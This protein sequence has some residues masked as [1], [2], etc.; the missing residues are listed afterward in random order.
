MGNSAELQV[1]IIMPAYNAERFIAAT[2]ESVLRQTCPHWELIIVDDGSEDSTANIAL[3]YADLDRR[4]RLVRQSHQ[5]LAEARNAGISLALGQ[6]IAFLDSDDLWAPEK[7]QRQIETINSTGA[8]LVYTDGY[9]FSNDD[10]GDRSRTCSIPIGQYSGDE[11]FALL[12]TR[13]RFAVSSVMLWRWCLDRAG[14]FDATPDHF[15]AEDYDLWL[16]LAG[17]GARFYGMPDRLIAYRV[18]DQSLSRYVRLM[19][20]S[21]GMVMR[22]HGLLN[23]PEGRRA[24]RRYA[25]VALLDEYYICNRNGNHDLAW[26]FMRQAWASSPATLCQP[27]RAAAVI[28]NGIM[29]RIFIT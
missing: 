20:N 26:S 6:L 9:V 5:R 19:I 15:G 16:T 11:M 7:L 29:A 14:R 4:I 24:L 13:N 2:I 22:K 23:R 12:A 10:S 18:H 17:Q 28:K 25:S 1:S 21:T 3:R 8:D 27:R